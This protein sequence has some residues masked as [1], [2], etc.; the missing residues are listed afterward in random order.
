MATPIQ[1]IEATEI[2]RGDV[3]WFAGMTGKHTIEDIRQHIDDWDGRE[4]LFVIKSQYAT[5]ETEQQRVKVDKTIM[6]WREIR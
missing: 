1:R 3:V 2:S 6:I 5:G 4:I